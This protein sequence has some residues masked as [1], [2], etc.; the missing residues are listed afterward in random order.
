VS[1]SVSPPPGVMIE[2]GSIANTMSVAS[3]EKSVA[4][5]EKSVAP[6]AEIVFGEPVV[7]P[8]GQTQFAVQLAAASSLQALKQ[9][10]GE[11]AERHGDALGSLRPRVAAPRS[12]GGFYRLLA[13][14]VPTKAD[15]ERICSQL[16]VGPKACF[17]TAYT[18][19]PL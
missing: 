7:T 16:G 15:A 2:T 14:P 13:G 6:K 4:S 17:A 18:G 5:K 3:K 9:S 12:E 10:W 8:A 19:S 11:L 1:L